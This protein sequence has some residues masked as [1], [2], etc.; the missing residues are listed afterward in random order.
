MLWKAVHHISVFEAGNATVSPISQM[1]KLK[2]TFGL[3]RGEV[4]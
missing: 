2:Q 3:I 4:L 1:K